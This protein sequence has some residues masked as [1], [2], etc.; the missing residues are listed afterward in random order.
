[1]LNKQN[2]NIMLYPFTFGD[3]MVSFN[4]FNF[5]P[6][7]AIRLQTSSIPSGKLYNITME[8]HNF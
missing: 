8:N 2:K 6:P 4:P 1:M 5:I 3:Q 7:V